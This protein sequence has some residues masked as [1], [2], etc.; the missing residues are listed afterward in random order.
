MEYLHSLC[1]SLQN[2]KNRLIYCS[3]DGATHA[4]V[5]VVV[6]IIIDVIK[7]IDFFSSAYT[8]RLVG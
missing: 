4:I 7:R 3:A 5:D 8:F 6:V 2:N 1:F